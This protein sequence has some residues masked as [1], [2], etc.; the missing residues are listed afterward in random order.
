MSRTRRLFI[1]RR[2]DSAGAEDGMSLIEVI[3]ALSIL[4]TLMVT[5]A[6]FFTTSL[7]QSNGQTQAQEAAVLAQQQLDYTRSVAAAS[8]LSGRCQTGVAAAVASPG[9]ADL[10]QDI[11]PGTLA[12]PNF[13]KSVSAPNAVDCTKTQAVPISSPQTVAGTLYTVTTFIDRCYVTVAANQTCTS[14]Y[15]GNGWIYRITVDVAYKLAGGRSCGGT[16][17]QFVASTLRDPGT[18]ACFNVNPL[19]AGCSTAQP[20][21]TQVSPSTVTTGS[22]TTMTLT[23]TNFDPG[24]TVSL[25]AG[26][27]AGT[28][29]NVNVISPTSQTFT[30]VSGNTPAAVRSQTLQVNNP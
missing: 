22:T 5:T 26:G 3:V 15:S 7:Q 24:A 12:N 11:L 1:L 25:L 14:T 17:C 19:Y 10:S 9:I 21:I 16:S 20:T 18:D 4:V 28:V 6:G 27:T 8:L 23:G 30:L 29:S 13:D 2:R